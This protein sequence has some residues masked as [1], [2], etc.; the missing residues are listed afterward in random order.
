VQATI[1]EALI[2]N[3]FDVASVDCFDEEPGEQF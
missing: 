1:A 3:K 2:I